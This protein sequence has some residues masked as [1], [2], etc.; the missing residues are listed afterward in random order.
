MTVKWKW[1]SSGYMLIK[2]SSSSSSWSLGWSWL[3]D[4]VW[5]ES[6][7]LILALK[8]K[9]TQTQQSERFLNE[10]G[11]NFLHFTDIDE[12]QKKHVACN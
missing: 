5:I 7:K 6:N 1:F 10:K 12:Q 9:Y 11:K 8:T 4:S 2:S 3:S